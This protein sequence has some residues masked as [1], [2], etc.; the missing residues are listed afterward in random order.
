MIG[1]WAVEGALRESGSDSLG[2]K[3]GCALSKRASS[4]S[5]RLDPVRL[6]RIALRSLVLGRRG[7]MYHIED[8]VR[9]DLD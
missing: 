4:G 5:T 9:G 2:I 1:I 3:A 8:F 6:R 7:R